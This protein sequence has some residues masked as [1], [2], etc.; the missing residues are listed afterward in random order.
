ML[1]V[2]HKT[3]NQF[4]FCFHERKVD[5]KKIKI[6]AL[7]LALLLT[8]FS[9][10]CCGKNIK[11][12]IAGTDWMWT[13]RG[14]V[15]TVFSFEED[16]TASMTA[17]QGEELDYLMQGAGVYSVSKNQIIITYD[18]DGE[19]IIDYK[20]ENGELILYIGND[21]LKKIDLDS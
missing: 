21:K 6:I 18:H 7:V 5:M 20:Y 2:F 11:K 12:D 14:S 10:I 3:L 15:Y 8:C 1:V 17:F 9:F 4:V 13:Y 16:G 19:T